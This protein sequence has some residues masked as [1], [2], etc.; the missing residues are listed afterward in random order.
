V[1]GRRRD[2]VQILYRIIDERVP[3]ICRA[4]CTQVETKEQL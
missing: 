4:V 2:G 3:A 1:L